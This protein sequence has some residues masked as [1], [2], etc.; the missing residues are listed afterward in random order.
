[1]AAAVALELLA[2]KGFVGIV[3]SP[4][5]EMAFIILFVPHF[6]L[7]K[8]HLEG[9]KEKS[10]AWG[11]WLALSREGP[12][13]VSL[14]T[15]QGLLSGRKLFCK[16]V[17]ELWEGKGENRDFPFGVSFCES[18][19]RRCSA[20]ISFLK[21]LLQAMTRALLSSTAAREAHFSKPQLL[22]ATHQ[23]SQPHPKTCISQQAGTLAPSCCWAFFTS[24]MIATACFHLLT[25]LLAQ[26][27]GSASDIAHWPAWPC[28]C[29]TSS[30]ACAYCKWAQLGRNHQI[31]MPE[32]QSNCLHLLFL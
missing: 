2:G 19:W 8:P 27:Q 16:P 11:C 7:A 21:H 28:C 25:F 3:T 32:E 31:S 4:P 30:T 13:A 23:L 29:F 17:L 12:L 20:P 6:S 15:P 14:S 10:S 5:K 9:E 24:A 26:S 18:T 22:L 1:M